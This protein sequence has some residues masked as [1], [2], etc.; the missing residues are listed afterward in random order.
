MK[1][2]HNTFLIAEIIYAEKENS[3]E[4]LETI[5]WDMLVYFFG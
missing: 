5:Y 3:M 4:N 1:V 2:P